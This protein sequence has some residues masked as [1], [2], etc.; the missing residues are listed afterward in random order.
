MSDCDLLSP[1]IG[2]SLALS[3]SCNYLIL[4]LAAVRS[5]WGFKTVI[6]LLSKV[7]EGL[8]GALLAAV[9]WG[10][11]AGVVVIPGKFFRSYGLCIL[12]VLFLVSVL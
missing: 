5:A 1:N 2:V 3:S 8:A 12:W 6:I 7:L 11:V 9:F 4:A 10:I